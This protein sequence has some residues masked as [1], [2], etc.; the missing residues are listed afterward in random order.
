MGRGK[1]RKSEIDPAGFETFHIEV[2]FRAGPLIHPLHAM[3]KLAL[4]FRAAEDL[5][6][7]IVEP[8]LEHDFALRPPLLARNELKHRALAERDRGRVLLGN[9]FSLIEASQLAALFER[10]DFV[11]DA[12][13]DPVFVEIGIGFI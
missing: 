3:E 12:G 8:L 2:E 7:G 5:E 6:R 13:F 10:N 4:E 11:C 1:I 9:T